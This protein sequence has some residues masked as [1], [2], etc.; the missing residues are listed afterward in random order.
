METCKEVTVSP[1][2][3][4]KTTTGGRGKSATRDASKVSASS[5]VNLVK[6]TRVSAKSAKTDDSAAVP[7]E[8]DDLRATMCTFMKNVEKTLKK[9]EERLEERFRQYDEMA[10]YDYCESYDDGGYAHDYESSQNCENSASGSVNIDQ[11]QVCNV[12]KNNNKRESDSRFA[13][14]AKKFKSQEFTDI[15]IDDTLAENVNGFFLQGIDE[16]RYLELVADEGNARPA[17]CDSLVTVK[18]NQM[19]W[20]GLSSVAKTNDRKLQTVETTVVKAATLLVKSVHEMSVLEKTDKTHGIEIDRCTEALA[21]LGHANRQ[22]N[23]ARRDLLK[24]EIRDDY[25]HL[26]NHSLPFTSELFGSDISKTAKEIED[27]ARISSKIRVN[28]GRGFANARTRYPYRG[29]RGRYRGQPMRGHPYYRPTGSQYPESK[30]YGQRSTP[31]R[32]A[33]GSQSKH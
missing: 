20:D 12:D 10:E 9:Q 7:V 11:D 3:K 26:C 33:R 1:S 19:I 22:I 31:S 8:H 27:V 5:G 4:E 25:V 28:R 17:N 30:N 6:S 14:L 23:L 2:K 18:T 29:F 21:L 13:G 24:P 16:K 15:E 32:G